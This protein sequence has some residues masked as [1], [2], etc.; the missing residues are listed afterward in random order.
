MS[1]K[2]GLP[3]PQRFLGIYKITYSRR[4]KR[5]SLYGWG[6]NFRCKGCIYK[7]KPPYKPGTP[8][9][10]LRKLKEALRGLD[11]RRVHFLGGEP[12][13]N[14]DLP[15]LAKFAH[16]ELGAYVKIGH[17]NGSR[18]PPRYVDGISIS[19]KAYTNELHVD[20]TGVPNDKVLDNFVKIYNMGLDLDASSVF[21]HGY[22]DCDEIEK[23]AKFIAD[24]DP[25]IPYHIIGYIPVPGAPWRAPSRDEV[26]EAARIAK[27]YLVNVTY[28]CLSLNEF[29]NLRKKDPRYES[30]RIL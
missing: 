25:K 12:T 16:E 9:I 14:P 18:I 19:I 3:I 23:I 1:A 22:I 4:F 28:S 21:I 30:I 11:V 15:E 13:I 29:L 7:L 17:S 6:C 5:A 27:K 20:Y 2:G 10:P 24:V 8:F 26:E